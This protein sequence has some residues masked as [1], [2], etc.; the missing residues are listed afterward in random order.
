LKQPRFL[1]CPPTY[2]GI[3]YVI[4]PWMEGQLHAADGALATE[5][6]RRFRQLVSQVADVTS[7]HP[8]AGLPDL[9]FTANAA[10]IY[11]RSAI[12]SNFRCLERRPESAHFAEWLAADGFDVHT[13]PEG[14]FFEG[15]GDA[16]FERG[17]EFLWA[18]HGFRS[19]ESAT[20]FLEQW[21]GVPVQLLRLQDPRFYHLDTCFCPLERDHLLYFSAAFDEPSNA[22]IEARFPP[23]RRLSVGEQDATSFACNAVNIGNQVILNRASDPLKAWLN[24]RGFH[25]AETAVSEFMKAGGATKCLSLR[26]EELA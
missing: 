19:H 2:F 24:A 6:W 4:N 1:L 15:A 7:I 14:V 10:L 25:V 3:E 12:L 22:A 11:R 26:L 9:V 23:D 20:P 21:T 8:V 17:R 18:G 13:L 16:L 5:Q